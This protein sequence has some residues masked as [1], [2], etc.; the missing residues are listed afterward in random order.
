MLG[1]LISH[2]FLCHAQITVDFIS[3]GNEGCEELLVNF[4]DQSYSSDGAILDWDWTYQLGNSS[5]QNPGVVFNEIGSFEVCLTVTDEANNTAQVCKPDY[6][7][8]HAKPNVDFEASVYG[9]CSPLNVEFQD[10]TTS[11]GEIYTW[12]WDVGGTSNVINTNDPDEMI[13]TTYESA[14][15]YSLSLTVIDENTCSNTVVKT[16]LIEVESIDPVEVVVDI[17]NS[18]EL[19]FTADFYIV[20]PEEDLEYEWFL[21]N[22]ESSTGD[23]VMNVFYP[24]IGLFDVFVIAKSNVC[25]DTTFFPELINTDPFVGFSASVEDLCLG[26]SISFIDNSDLSADSLI[27]IF[28]DGIV[29]NELEPSHIYSEEGCYEVALVRYNN[30]CIDTLISTDC[31]NVFPQPSF[32][33]IVENNV[34]CS[35]PHVVSVTGTSEDSGVFEWVVSGNT[36]QDTFI[37]ESFDFTALDYGTYDLSLS[38]TSDTGCSELVDLEPIYISPFEINLPY[39][40][41]IGCVPL[42]FSLIDSIL[43]NDNIVFYDWSINTN[44]VLQSND[45]SPNFTVQDTGSFA[46]TLIAENEI[47][48]RDT[49]VV[50]NYINA[51]IPPEVDFVVNPQDTCASALWRFESIVSQYT[52]TWF[53][54]FGQDTSSNEPNPEITF[55]NIDSLDVGLIALHH[56]CPSSLF[57]ENFINLWAPTAGIKLNY[58]CE[59]PYEVEIISMSKSADSIY[60]TLE[61]ETG[62]FNSTDSVFNYTFDARGTYPISIESYNFTTGCD[63]FAK[64][65]IVISDPVAFYIPDTTKICYPDQ[66]ILTDQSIDAEEYLFT[67]FIGNFSN[68]TNPNQTLS[69]N[70]PGAYVSPLLVITDVH[71]CQ[72]SFRLDDS[73]YVNKVTANPVYDQVIC[74]PNF[75]QFSD[76]S[77]SLFGTLNEWYW[78]IGSGFHT[79][80]TPNTSKTFQ[81]VDNYELSFYVKD[82]WNCEDLLI[83]TI[84]TNTFSIDFSRD[85]I[86]CEYGGIQFESFT[87]NEQVASYTWTFGDG[88]TSNEKNPFHIYENE[89][90][91]NICLTIVATDGC[92]KFICLDEAV[93]IVNPLSAFTANPTQSTCPPLL[94]NFENQSV[95]TVEYIWSFGDN[96]GTS[97]LENPSHV[98]TSPG[99]F[100]VSLIAIMNERCQDTLLL[101][102]FININGPDANFEMS[103]DSSCLPVDIELNAQSNGNYQYVWDFGNGIL[104]SIPG[105]VSSNTSVYSYSE[106]GI[107]TPRLI[108]SDTAGCTRSFSGIPVEVHEL[109]LDFDIKNTPLC[110]TPIEVGVQNNS[111]GTKPIQSYNWSLSGPNNFSSNDENPVFLVEQ[112]G[113]YD[114]ELIAS[115]GFCIDTLTQANGV[116]IE[117]YPE[118]YFEVSSETICQETEVQFIN[119]STALPGSTFLWEFGDGE[120]SIENN[121]VLFF[122]EAGSY[123]V[124]LTVTSAIGC[125]DTYEQ[126]VEVLINNVVDA[127]EEVTICQGEEVEISGSVTGPAGISSIGWLSDPDIACL[128]CVTTTAAPTDTSIYFF[129][130][131]LT[132]GCRQIDSVIV[133]VAPVAIPEITLVPDTIICQRDSLIIEI[134]NY[135]SDYEYFWMGEHFNCLN[136]SCQ[137][138]LVYPEDQ[139]YYVVD[140]INQYG[141]QNRDSLHINVETTFEDIVIEDQT[142]CRYDSIQL[143]VDNGNNAEWEFSSSLSC[144]DCEQPW[145]SPTESEVFYVSVLSNNGCPFSDTLSIEVIPENFT[146]AGQDDTLCLGEVVTL[147]GQAFGSIEWIPNLY[148]SDNTSLFPDSSPEESISYVL[149]NVLGSCTQEDTVMLTVIEKADIQAI[150][151]TVCPGEIALVNGFGLAEEFEWFDSSG[152]SLG[153]EPEFNLYPDS[154]ENFTLIGRL[155]SCITDTAFANV[156]LQDGVVIELETDISVYSNLPYAFDIIYDENK[157]YHFQWSPPDGLSCANCPDPTITDL[158]GSVNYELTV[159]DLSSGCQI[160]TI[161]VARYVNDCT[162]KAFYIPNVFS[163]N[164]DGVNDG[165]R[166]FAQDEEEFEDLYIYDR[167]GELMFYTDDISVEWDGIFQN[168]PLNPAVFGIMVNAFCKE[169]GEPYS[170][171]KSVTIVR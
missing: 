60:W 169:T 87:D 3:S 28:G 29:S 123:N 15:V 116:V 137:S 155:G 100:D 108:V 44:P 61:L 75:A 43:A 82:D 150:G 72:D 37:G 32:D 152:A 47:G 55:N 129:E 171:S 124:Q 121:P 106:T 151:D 11:D 102:D 71:N 42:D 110:G 49:L 31:I 136:D 130:V 77:T 146:Y 126:V 125:I 56:G 76:N 162:E 109:N 30:N 54:Q 65:T 145:A 91:Y 74:I 9:G 101:E 119:L 159:I 13:S 165:Y 64:D 115:I 131:V 94:V 18:C 39:F 128:T 21:G 46:L 78:D 160:D 19:P 16:E 51:G 156:T 95:N 57:K 27:W 1:C 45:V 40:G 53:W 50:P 132:N 38:Y 133:N 80:T 92:V 48:C 166:V 120:N 154:S 144:N 163:P 122:N 83:D 111:E 84:R 107:Y 117:D 68:P 134:S 62:V 164:G 8:I 79:A 98:Y 142:I 7:V 59:Q 67:D 153:T 14:G 2:S 90:L 143:I 157:D 168:E 52:D 141:C 69:F 96:S 149:R 140:V 147:H 66:I 36:V 73:L 161:I 24:D 12:L 23:S 89:G 127:G 103:I 113:F 10:L 4:Y 85:S 22:G 17:T 158:S 81:V 139:E 118:A 112:E 88:N 26:N 5:Q 33:V 20:N 97:N 70:E 63:H 25:A 35:F 138:I 104:D 148:L 167:W 41:P 93:E 99:S 105:L 86:G 170:F 135:N 34:A 6:I 114:I 58:S